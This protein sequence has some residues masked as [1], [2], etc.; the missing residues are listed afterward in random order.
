MK[1]YS[2]NIKRVILLGLIFLIMVPPTGI[3]HTFIAKYDLYIRVL[4]IA[5][6]GFFYLKKIIKEKRVDIFLIVLNLYSFITIISAYIHKTD[7]FSA[8]WLYWIN[9]NAIVMFIDLSIEKDETETLY[10]IFFAYSFL[11]I[12]DFIT[13]M[14]LKDVGHSYVFYNR[15]I[16]IRFYLLALFAGQMLRVKGYK[17]KYEYFVMLAI[18]FFMIVRNKGMTSLVVITIWTVYVLFINGKWDKVFN[19]FTYIATG[20]VGLLTACLNPE[21]NP[22]VIFVARLLKKTPSFSGR[23]EI[24][25]TCFESIKQNPIIGIGVNNSGI[26]VPSLNAT[27]PDSHSSYVQLFYSVGILG[28]AVF[29]CLPILGVYNMVKLKDKKIIGTLS[30]LMF[31]LIVDSLFENLNIT[32]LISFISLIYFISKKEIVRLNHGELSD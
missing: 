24:W 32:I 6:I 16:C 20:V 26:S 18:A 12:L 4:T 5:G 21:K 19:I 28:A 17:I 25:R 23:S 29:A 30:I 7:V 31:C 8:I 14:A 15:N 1:E 11:L 27:F 13:N 2:I 9:V 22:I 3:D 10:S